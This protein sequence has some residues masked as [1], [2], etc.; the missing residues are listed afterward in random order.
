MV[1]LIYDQFF[2]G[3]INMRTIKKNFHCLGCDTHFE[4]EVPWLSFG[5]KPRCPD[6][7]SHERG[8]REDV[9]RCSCET[10]RRRFPGVVRIS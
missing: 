8:S 5:F 6:K 3:G 1:L 2:K 7:I 9:V 10:S 4:A